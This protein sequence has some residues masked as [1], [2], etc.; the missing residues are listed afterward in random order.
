M[1]LHRKTQVQLVLVLSF[2]LS[3]WCPPDEE[4]SIEKGIWAAIAAVG[5]S[6]LPSPTRESQTLLA[7]QGVNSTVGF[8]D[9]F[10]FGRLWASCGW[11]RV[12]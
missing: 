3:R 10:L 6:T 12:D 4:F 2:Q 7:N 1:Y 8:G 9:T 11:I 5:K